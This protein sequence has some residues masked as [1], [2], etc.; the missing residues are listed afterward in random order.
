MQRFDRRV[1]RLV[2][3]FESSDDAGGGRLV[4]LALAWWSAEAPD[5]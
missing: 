3:D 4:S 1:K 2:N 5:A